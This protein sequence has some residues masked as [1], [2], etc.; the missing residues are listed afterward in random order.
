MGE[1]SVTSVSGQ[2]IACIMMAAFEKRTLTILFWLYQLVGDVQKDL[3][4]GVDIMKPLGSHEIPT[5][6]QLA[7][8]LRNCPLT[9]RVA[10]ESNKNVYSQ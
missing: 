8:R 9:S 10:V 1:L 6:R 4:K 5:S 7:E 3:L 2:F